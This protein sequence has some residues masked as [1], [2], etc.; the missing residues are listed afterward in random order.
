[1]FNRYEVAM[2]KGRDGSGERLSP[3]AAGQLPPVTSTIMRAR[4]LS[5][6]GQGS[7]LGS[8]LTLRSRRAG[9]PLLEVTF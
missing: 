5:Q 7:S 2:V 8:T 6:V 4:L 9:Q 1:M 3:A